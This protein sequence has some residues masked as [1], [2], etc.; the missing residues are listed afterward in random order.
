[1]LGRLKHK[2]SIQLMLHKSTIL[3]SCTLK[4]SNLYEGLSNYLLRQTD[5]D[6]KSEVFEPVWAKTGASKERKVMLKISLNPVKESFSALIKFKSKAQVIM[7]IISLKGEIVYSE[8]FILEE[9]L[10]EI[11][12]DHPELLKEG[13]YIV[14]IE[15]NNLIVASEKILKFDK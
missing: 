11:H 12:F 4:D 14:N 2:H 1:M 13:L 9:G 8:K 5:Y 3:H 7:K 15:E 10:N 6:G